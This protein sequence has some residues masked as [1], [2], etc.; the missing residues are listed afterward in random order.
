MPFV[1]KNPGSGFFAHLPTRTTFIGRS[2]ELLF[3]V[4]E[5]LKP[6]EPTHNILSIWGQGGVGKTTLLRHYK[7]QAEMAD[8]KAY[9]LTAIV[10]ERQATP[11]SMMEQCAQQLHLSHTFEKALNRY[12]EALQFLPPTRSSPSLQ[13]TLVNRAPDMTGALLE[14]VPLA[15]PLLREGAKAVTEHL[16][17]HYQTATEHTTAMTFHDPLHTLT[18][19]FITELNH[20]A[21]S[22]VTLPPIRTKRE[23][24]ILLFFDTFEHVADEAVPWLL[25]SVLPM[26]MNSNIVF[27][28]AGRNPL[29][30]STA[31]GPKPWLPYYDDH[32]ISALPLHPFT[33]EETA[34]YLAERGISRK[35]HIDPIWHLSHGLPLYLGLLIAN[36]HG[37]LDPTKDVVDNFLQHIPPSE[38][39][40]RRLALDAALFSKPFNLDDLA[41]FPYLSEQDRSTLY[42]WLIRQPFVR[43]T[44]LQGR[45]LY[46]DVAQDLFQRYLFQSSP[47]TYYATR[48]TLATYYQRQLDHLQT[49]LEKNQYGPS[50]ERLEVMLALAWQRFFLP[51]EESHLQALSPL[52]DIWEYEDFEQLE[53]LLRMLDKTVRLLSQTQPDS[54]AHQV[55]QTFLHFFETCPTQWD[56][57]QR[58][59][60]LLATDYLLKLVEHSNL[61]E[62]L[63][64]IYNFCGWGY[65][66]LKEHQQ[67]LTWFER[68][69]KLHP[70]S[71]RI[72]N[73]LGWTHC[74]LKHYRQA[75]DHFNYGL[76]LAPYH[77]H[78]YVGRGRVY[79]KLKAYQQALHDYSYAIQ[80]DRRCPMAYNNRARTYMELKEYRK[81]LADWNWLE[82][83]PEHPHA[84]SIQVRRGCAHLWLKDLPQATTCF[85]RS[86]E[87]ASRHKT[88][89][90]TQDFI[91]WVREWS[92]MGQTSP[93]WHTL[94]HL[95]AISERGHYT[96]SV[97]RGVLF[98]LRPR[99]AQRD[100][101]RAY[102]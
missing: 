16:L 44:S 54:Y 52:L 71:V 5:F 63:A 62:L 89:I 83:A 7:Q 21:V 98:L 30:R 61:S 31:A 40:K 41:A 4:Q 85:T 74:H 29:E 76:E 102:R 10:D 34:A 19:V 35:E 22:T 93:T 17:D 13:H 79:G 86:Y 8:F 90:G 69:L 33:Y 27:I 11:A 95:E 49:V 77:P 101:V 82:A 97:C 37:A 65:I 6:E 2:N 92:I 55:A 12:K 1:K 87:L 94:H 3:F 59:E 14:G 58:Q 100:C 47:N 91:L 81:A 46:H 45:Y 28:I 32:S 25:Y 23:R 9:C 36:S 57:T 42:E 50:E 26:N 96:A 39:I 18:H 24:R 15:G 43:A 56:Q 51:D 73:S 48:R 68:A 70:H 53:T 99:I 78:L 80:L 72:Q 67:A 75:L 38:P 20:L 60:W 84:P 66:R 88:S 64:H